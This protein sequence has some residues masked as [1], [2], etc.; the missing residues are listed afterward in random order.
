MFAVCVINLK[1]YKF[2][3]IRLAPFQMSFRASAHTG[4][5]IPCIVPEIA[6]SGFALLAMTTGMVLIKKNRTLRNAVTI[7][8]GSGN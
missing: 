8:S 1:F 2:L 3:F 6:T 7:P 5:G 4:V